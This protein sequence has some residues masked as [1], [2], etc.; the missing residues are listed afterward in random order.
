MGLSLRNIGKKITDFASRGYDQINLFDDGRSYKTRTP[1][2]TSSVL[3]QANNTIVK[4][5]VRPVVQGVNTVKAGVG[6]AYGLGKIGASSVFGSDQD[7]LNTVRGVDTTMTRDLN[8]NSGLMGMGTYFKNRDELNAATPRMIAGKAIN[9]GTQLAQ[10]VAPEL[11]VLKNPVA[12][13]MINNAGQSLVGSTVGQYVETGKIDPR[14]LAED[15]AVGT[16]M[17]EVIP[18]VKYVAGKAVPVARKTAGK[19]NE[20]M[21]YPENKVKLSDNERGTISDYADMLR[22]GYVPKDAQSINNLHVHARQIAEKVGLDI[23]SGSPFD[24]DMRIANF[25]ESY[26]KAGQLREKGGYVQIGGE[27]PKVSL[28]KIDP[29]DPMGNK[30]I[31]KRIKNELGSVYDDDS[32]MISLL[33]RIEKETGRKGLVDQWY[34][35]T[36][37][38]KLSTTRANAKMVDNQN[39]REAYEGL[40]RKEL[41]Q[42]DEYSIARRELSYD[43]KMKTSKPR[44]EL[45]AIRDKYEA[46]YGSRFDARKRAVDDLTNELEKEGIISKEKA[47]MWR[48]NQDY[49]R[50]QRDMEDLLGVRTSASRSRSISTTSTKQKVTG[51]KREALSAAA[52]DLQRRQQLEREIQRNKAATHTIDAL[53]SAGL[54]TRL[55]NADDVQ[56]RRQAFKTMKELKPVRDAVKVEADKTAKIA[57]ELVDRNKKLGPEVLSRMEG[58][59]PEVRKR[60]VSLANDGKR[61]VNKPTSKRLAKAPTS[62]DFEEAFQQYL[63]GDSTLVRKMYEFMGN[64]R[65]IERVQNKLDGLRAQYDQI[66]ADRKDLWL[67]AKRHADLSTTNKNTI[68]RFKD[69]IR[70]VY[71]V[72][73]DIKK[74]VENV[75]PYQ[76]GILSRIISVP[77]RVLRAGATG[78]NIAFAGVN[79][80]RDQVT[81][82]ILS[83]DV[84][85]T[86]NPKNII[87]G[88]WNA[89]KGTLGENDNELWKMFT[90]FAGDR[91]VYDDLRNAKS[92]KRILRE[93]RMGSKGKALNMATAPLRT[94]ED[95]ISIT[96]KATRFQNFKG[97]YEKARKQGLSEGE[98][99]TK[100]Y[101]AAAQNSVDFNRSSNFTRT[102]NIVF[103]YFN[104]GVQGSRSMAR[105]FKER[106]LQTSA[107]SL[108]F[109]GLPAMAATAYNMSTKEGRAAWDSIDDYEKE[110]NFI[111]IM[112]GAHQTDSGSWEGIIKI[113]KPQGFRE[114]TQPL[115]DITESFISKQPNEDSAMQVAQKILEGITGPVSIGSVGELE[116]SFVPQLAKPFVQQAMN[117]DLYSGKEIVPEYMKRDSDNPA[118][119]KYDSTSGTA[120]LVGKAINRS[121]LQVE[122]FVK[123]VFGSVG[124]NMI[125]AA[126]NAIA[127]VKGDNK[128]TSQNESDFTIGGRSVKGEI[129]RRTSQASGDLLDENKTPGQKYYETVD[130]VMKESG[131]DRNE[132]SAWNTLHPAKKNFMG[133]EIFDEN[134]RLSAHTRAS[135]YLQYPKVFIADARIDALQR[136][137]GKPG[138][139]IYDLPQEQLTRVLLK[140]TLPPGA[141]D[142]ELSNLYQ[143]EW[144]QDYNTKRDAYYQAI[145]ADMAKEGKTMPASTNPYPEAPQDLQKAMDQYSALPKGTGQRS[146]WISANPG[147]WQQMTNHWSAVDAWENKERVS[148]GLSP[149]D[150]TQSSTTGGY[151]YGN[152]DSTY[153]TSNSMRYAV[154]L[155]AGGSIAKPKISVKGG[156]TSTKKKYSV[157]K[158]KVS[159]KKSMV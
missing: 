144:Y 97:I 110:D 77:S 107:K 47:D 65:E 5:F 114:L 58:A 70:E 76:L 98:A 63:D 147:L 4:P 34:V 103:P 136:A 66:K 67:D 61:A 159:I 118:D 35:D 14:K 141:K 12:N 126:D 128:L 94:L 53:E 28:S 33:R 112:P 151:G 27:K 150:N 86:H 78:F 26:D 134:N 158:P 16:A 89:T 75:S 7:Y 119:W 40:K 74:V 129:L 145:K 11:K 120:Q 20:T 154:S 132:E 24:R 80:I 25:L 36:N 92:S 95:V 29:N 82:S 152:K 2:Q 113:P 148:M 122:K 42:F 54:T 56:A 125:N 106:P 48:S 81:S 60:A 23:T 116:G 39:L 43:P 50:I 57:K 17:G 153:G 133:E 51:S 59:A 100:A 137:Q 139:P 121:P 41:K 101:L 83:K 149:I 93:L 32:A 105:A 22:G 18:T 73:P 37:E 130:K 72:H 49:T 109:V 55:V 15:V 123:D 62:A 45:Q 124:S 96:E 88:V 44:K 138:N 69:G 84:M 104:A 142:P 1:T 99:Y 90:E 127:W 108:A 71:E 102:M 30:S 13:R 46:Q 79:Y 85:A 31:L 64:K 111:I 146:A 8:P 52:S 157:A 143:Q 115:Q 6:G 19:I 117:Q 155:N 10:F 9:E 3:S 21:Y 156:S 131:L 38:V 87:S 68:S 140:A 91:T 135:I